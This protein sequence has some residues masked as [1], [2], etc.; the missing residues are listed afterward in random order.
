M[1]QKPVPSV[2]GDPPLPRE[3][4][5]VIQIISGKVQTLAYCL[6]YNKSESLYSYTNIKWQNVPL[7]LSSPECVVNAVNGLDFSDNPMW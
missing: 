7:K 1:Q 2:L 5:N 3:N 6:V 4:Y